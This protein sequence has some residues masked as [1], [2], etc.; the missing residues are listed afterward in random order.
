MRTQMRERVSTLFPDVTEGALKPTSACRLG[1]ATHAGSG[2]YPV[3]QRAGPR[4][5]AAQRHGARALGL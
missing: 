5:E 4:P 2:L 3:P 1:M